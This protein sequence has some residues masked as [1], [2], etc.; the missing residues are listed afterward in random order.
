M[1]EW[2]WKTKTNRTSPKQTLKKSPNLIILKSRIGPI[3]K[4]VSKNGFIQ[5]ED[6]KGHST[7]ARLKQA[8]RIHNKWEYVVEHQN[9]ETD[10]VTPTDRFTIYFKGV[11][12]NPKKVDR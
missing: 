9:G 2:L 1:F 5:F 8:G 11:E 4:Y 6:G 3:K 12:M 7:K 10:I